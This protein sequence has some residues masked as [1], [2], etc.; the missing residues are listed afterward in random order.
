MRV[1][2]F[3]NHVHLLFLHN[4]RDDNFDA[5]SQVKNWAKYLQ[6]THWKFGDCDN[7][8]VI[9]YSV[10]DAMVRI[11]LIMSF[12]P[13]CLSFVIIG[14]VVIS[15]RNYRLRNHDN[16]VCAEANINAVTTHFFNN[17]LSR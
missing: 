5:Q 15:G 3:A 8:I 9:V 6:E 16:T 13:P 11:S 12:Q 4:D 10:Y 2:S 7:D 17:Q 14:L 1:L